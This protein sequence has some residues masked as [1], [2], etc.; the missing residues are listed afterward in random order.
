MA[1]EDPVQEKLRSMRG[2]GGGESAHQLEQQRQEAS[3]QRSQEQNGQE[4]PS[5]EEQGEE[6]QGQ[7][8]ERRPESY[9]ERMQREAQ[10]QQQQQQ[11]SAEEGGAEG[12]G[13]EEGG[14]QEQGGQEQGGQ[15]QGGEEDPL[16]DNPLIKARRDAVGGEPISSL[17]DLTGRAKSE[18][19]IEAEKPEDILQEFKKYKQSAEKLGEVEEQRDQIKSIIDNL[20]EE[21]YEAINQWYEEGKDPREV[22]NS[23]PNL[24]FN[25]TEDDVPE[26]ELLNSYFPNEFSDEDLESIKSG[27]ADERLQKAYN[28]T[29]KRAKE[30]FRSDKDRFKNKQKER[31]ESIKDRQKQFKES[32]DRSLRTFSEK[33]PGADQEYVE[34]VKEV[35]ADPS[36]LFYDKSGTLKEDAAVKVALAQNGYELVDRYVQQQ[37]TEAKNEVRR[38]EVKKKPDRPDPQKQKGSGKGSQGE[39]S[40]EVKK[41]LGD[42]DRL[43]KKNTYSATGG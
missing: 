23:R 14:G 2:L 28:V 38:E 35:L 33:F 17:E 37:R 29:L 7:G 19:G 12:Q 21:M 9:A 20:P 16:A 31:D 41:K 34:G 13:E 43:R 24:D 1:E 22:I 3:E 26:R 8:E 36:S 15:E 30:N 32:L 5:G 4:Q 6:E 42:L 27:D 18:L 40:E 11:Q 39:L 25:R 10:E